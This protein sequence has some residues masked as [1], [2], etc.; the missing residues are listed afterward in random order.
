VECSFR[1]CSRVSACTAQYVLVGAVSVWGLR[2]AGYLHHRNSGKPEDFRY[3][4][5]RRKFGATWWWR[6][7]FQVFALQGVIMYLLS[8]PLVTAL[9][10]N[11]CIESNALTLIGA[12]V[13]AIGLA[14]EAT[15]DFQLSSFKSD[16][17]NKGKLMTHGLFAYTRHPN[18]FGDSVVWWGLWLL[19]LA[20]GAA[21]WTIYSPALM[22][23]LLVRVSGVAFLEHYMKKRPG[24]DEYMRRTSSFVP[25]PPK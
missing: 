25:M 9:N 6:S 11:V 1:L 4:A 2:L 16:P 18:Y 15:A 5:W 19:S 21:W 17:Q 13:W 23:F 14:F 24:Y 20:C 22:S 10:S 3:A 7:F 12:A 8:V